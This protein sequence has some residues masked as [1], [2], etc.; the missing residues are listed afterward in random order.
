MYKRLPWFGL[1]ILIIPIGLLTRHYPAIFPNFAG[2]ILYAT[3][4]FFCARFLFAHPP[5]WKV[6]L[7]AFIFCICIELQQLYRAPW[8]IHL[9][10]TFPFGLIL[11]YDFLYSDCLCYL[12]GVL[13]GYLPAQ[14]IASRR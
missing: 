3:C 4:A 8:I 14:F 12:I 6:A 5:L 1:F 10:H 7:G 9:R 13:L 2:D 11:G